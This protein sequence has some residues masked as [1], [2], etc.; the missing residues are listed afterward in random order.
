MGQA[1]AQ[2][3]A[4][5]S[6]ELTQDMNKALALNKPSALKVQFDQNY[7]NVFIIKF[8]NFIILMLEVLYKKL[9]ILIILWNILNGFYKL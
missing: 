6:S 2:I 9:I 7:G 8:Y 1:V 5:T 4:K 3:N